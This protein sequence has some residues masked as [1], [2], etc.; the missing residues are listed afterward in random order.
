[1]GSISLVVGILN[2]VTFCVLGVI[3]APIA[4]ICGHMALTKAKQSPV[5]PAPGHTH[6]VIGVILGYAGLIVT[7]IVLLGLLLFKDQIQG[8]TPPPP[9]G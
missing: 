8:I 6:A 9:N 4:V 7:L 5:K 2:T 1:M 3:L